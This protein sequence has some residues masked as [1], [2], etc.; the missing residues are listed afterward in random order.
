MTDDALDEDERR[1]L[2]ALAATPYPAVGDCPEDVLQ[3]LRAR[4]LVEAVL[5]VPLPLPT[6][7]TG[8]RITVAGEAAL[9]GG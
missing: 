7:R 1:C 6:I 5:L 3:R 2:A 8:Y 4:R 9:R